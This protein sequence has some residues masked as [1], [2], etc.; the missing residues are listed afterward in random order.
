MVERNRW[1][2]RVGI[3]AWAA[4]AAAVVLLVS[5]PAAAAASTLYVNAA[6]GTDSA[7]CG[8]STS[9][10]RTIQRAVDNATDGDTIEVAAGA[11]PDFVSIDKSVTVQ[12]AQAGNAGSAARAAAPAGESVIDNHVDITASN[13]TLDG[14]SSDYPGTQLFVNRSPDTTIEN[15]VFT[16]Y[17]PDDYTGF[18][19]TDAI[20]VNAAPGTTITRNYFTSP[21]SYDGAINF[22]NGGCSDTVISDNAFYAAA[23]DGL[24]TVFFFCQNE[25]SADLTISGNDD[26][27]VGDTNG[28]SF[29]VAEAVNG[30]IHVTGNSVT[31]DDPS[32]V[33]YFTLSPNL[34]AVDVSGNS[35]VGSGS[36]AVTIRPTGGGAGTSYTITGNRLSGGA[37]GLYVYPGPLAAGAT[38]TAHGNVLSGNSRYG[39]F[40][41]DT[42]YGSSLDATENWWGCNAGPAAAGCSAESGLTRFDPWLVLG[43][44]A[45]PSTLP[46]GSSSTVTADVTH[47]SAGNDASAS[48]TIPDGTTIAFAT[49]FGTLSAPAAGTTDGKAS[50]TLTSAAPGTA[51]VSATLDSQTVSTTVTF[52]Q[53]FPTSADQCKQGGW[54]SFGNFKNQ[55][56]CVSYVA[57][58]GRNRP[59]G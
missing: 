52:T 18:R 19:I 12:G 42:A 29:L 38:V 30:D 41:G 7:T 22:F 48:G 21:G 37:Y 4:P 40:N 59:N 9:P 33:L 26:V 14:F 47:D 45:S 55:G 8:P 28:E 3:A 31:A 46:A 24:G 32:S 49:D 36:S 10:C 43:I 23:N 1:G 6:T 13:V 58:G 53:R 35:I 2:R 56:D 27:H 57:T 15:N 50:V 11:Y 44:S 17:Q 34:G 39:V 5:A 54:Q 51:D 25:P 20:G 16:G